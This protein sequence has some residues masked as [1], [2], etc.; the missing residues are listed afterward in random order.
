MKTALP[1]FGLRWSAELDTIPPPTSFSG[2]SV[3][4]CFAT[5]GVAKTISSMGYPVGTLSS[6][7]R[8]AAIGR[9]ITATFVIID[10]SLFLAWKIAST[11]SCGH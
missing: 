1:R 2:Q 5:S 11:V 8:T 3:M 6:V 9:L 7:T 4:N 10:R